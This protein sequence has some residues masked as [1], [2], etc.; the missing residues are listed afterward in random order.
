MSC[1][2]ECKGTRHHLWVGGWAGW[3]G[4]GRRGSGEEG[5]QIV[6]PAAAHV[7]TDDA[8]TV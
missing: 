8:M 7:H 4:E 5:R 2:W 1:E 6:T 3:C